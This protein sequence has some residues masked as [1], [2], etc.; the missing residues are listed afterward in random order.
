MYRH[1]PPPSATPI[2]NDKGFGDGQTVK[3]VALGDGGGG[4]QGRVWHEFR[5]KGV[6]G[7]V[8]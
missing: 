7:G 3:V 6:P 4:P 5:C 8:V 2:S 1:Q